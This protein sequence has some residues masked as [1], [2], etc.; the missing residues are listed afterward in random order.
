MTQ[1]YSL[2]FLIRS[3]FYDLRMKPSLSLVWSLSVVPS[4]GTGPGSANPVMSHERLKT[5]PTATSL[6]LF[7]K[8]VL[9]TTQTLES[10]SPLYSSG[11]VGS[12]SH[13]PSSPG[14]WLI[15]GRGQNVN[16]ILSFLF[17]NGFDLQVRSGTPVWKS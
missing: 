1:N 9:V 15:W 12:S 10:P 5:F 17:H 3:Y 2:S 8:C 6:L 7:Q 11:A 16:C 14:T 13:V 4:V